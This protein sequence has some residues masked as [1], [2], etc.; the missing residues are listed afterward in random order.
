M[1]K[2]FPSA[3]KKAARDRLTSLGFKRFNDYYDA[4]PLTSDACAFVQVDANRAIG[5]AADQFVLSTGFGLRIGSLHRTFAVLSGWGDSPDFVGI[6]YLPL[7]NG[8]RASRLSWRVR[9]GQFPQD[10]RPFLEAVRDDVLPKLQQYAS[11]EAACRRL[12]EKDNE[13]LAWQ[14]P[15]WTPVAYLTLGQ[16]NEALHFAEQE[17]QSACAWMPND[18]EY[19]RAYT[20]YVEAL[21]R[22]VAERQLGAADSSRP[23]RS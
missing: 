7:V 11:A 6:T 10:I 1:G 16:R 8:A 12:L 13:E 3:L 5:E 2:V 17:L 14:S 22:Q 15:W 21:R 20:S 9:S 19:V 4:R 18:T 23:G